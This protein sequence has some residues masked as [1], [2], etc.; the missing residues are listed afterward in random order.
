MNPTLKRGQLT[1]WKDERGF[2]FIQP[3]DG[4]QD[5][6][7]HISVLKTS[8]R[9]PQVGDTI[10]YRAITKGKKVRACEAFISGARDS[11]AKEQTASPSRH[12][13][14]KKDAKFLVIAQ[15]G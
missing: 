4:G 8:T 13:P 14:R 10:Y 15:P 9:R 11:G 5:V 3:A 2:G 6:F 7:L 1:I 12:N